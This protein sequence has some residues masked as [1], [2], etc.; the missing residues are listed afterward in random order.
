V[1]T[2]P[3]RRVRRRLALGAWALI[4]LPAAAGAHAV[5]VRALPPPGVTLRAAP[6]RV[7]LWFSARLEPAYSAVSVWSEGAKVAGRKTAGSADDSRRLTLA[8]PPLP[9]GDYT[10]RYRVL[11]LDGHIVE[12]AYSFTVLGGAA[13]R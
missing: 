6:P 4:L 5:L 9:G 12:G 7:Q 2:G 8:L 13:R 1:V 3:A 11:A 10:V